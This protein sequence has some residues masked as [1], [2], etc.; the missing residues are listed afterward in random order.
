MDNCNDTGL[1]ELD[2]LGKDLRFEMI[3]EWRD[4]F[5]VCAESGFCFGAEVHEF[6]AKTT[7]MVLY[8]AKAIQP[9]GCGCSWGD[10]SLELGIIDACEDSRYEIRSHDDVAEYLQCH[11]DTPGLEDAFDRLIG[12]EVLVEEIG[13]STFTT[14]RLLILADEERRAED[15]HLDSLDRD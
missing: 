13:G 11:P 6:E 10:E 9:C 4:G 5:S 3:Q 1:P 7:A 8:R 2:V 12:C 14:Q 15:R